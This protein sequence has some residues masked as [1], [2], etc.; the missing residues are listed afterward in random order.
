MPKWWVFVFVFDENI[1]IFE[2]LTFIFNFLSCFLLMLPAPMFG[3]TLGT[4]STMSKHS[5]HSSKF[6]NRSIAGRSIERNNGCASD[7]LDE[8]ICIF[9]TVS[10]KKPTNSNSMNKMPIKDWCAIQSFENNT[11][12][13]HHLSHFVFQEQFHQI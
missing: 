4:F 2:L 8:L 7:F 9:F 12:S 13:K 5:V 6:A 11:F 1:F 3:A 10:L